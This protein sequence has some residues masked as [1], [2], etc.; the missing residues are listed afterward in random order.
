M[1]ACQVS[2]GQPTPH[3]AILFSLNSALEQQRQVLTVHEDSDYIKACLDAGALA[4]VSKARTSADLLSAI[5]EALVGHSFV[6]P[7]ALNSPG[8]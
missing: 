8:P 1:M 3:T 5:Q 2:G 4:Y 6:S 7:I